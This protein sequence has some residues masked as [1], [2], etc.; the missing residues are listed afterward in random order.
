MKGYYVVCGIS[1]FQ[2]LPPEAQ[3]PAVGTDLP[4]IEDLFRDWMKMEAALKGLP[5]EKPSLNLVLKQI[6]SW[7]GNL[8][9]E[10]S[11]VLYI[12]THGA[13]TATGFYLLETDVATL[14]DDSFNTMSCITPRQ[15]AETISK[16]SLKQVL[17]ILDCCH[18]AKG[19]TE[20]TAVHDSAD[21]KLGTDQDRKVDFLA[22]SRTAAV[23]D[24]QFAPAFSKI[25]RALGISSNDPFLSLPEIVQSLKSDPALSGDKVWHRS[26]LS[27]TSPCQRL[28]NGSA[29]G[30]V[31]SESGKQRIVER[32]AEGMKHSGESTAGW[33]CFAWHESGMRR[34]S[35]NRATW[36]AQL[37]D[38]LG[39]KSGAIALLEGF[40]LMT[41]SA[42]PAEQIMICVQEE[43]ATSIEPDLLAKEELLKDN[44][45]AGR[46]S[47]EKY[48]AWT[49]SPT[50]IHIER[51][52]GKPERRSVVI[53]GIELPEQCSTDDGH[54]LKVICKPS[55]SIHFIVPVKS[56]SDDFEGVPVFGQPVG[57]R[58]AVTVHPW[59]RWM[60]QDQWLY[61]R[62]DMFQKWKD[63]DS[64]GSTI[65]ASGD[66]LDELLQGGNP[67][68]L[69]P[70]GLSF[71]QAATFGA[72]PWQLW[73]RTL[74]AQR[75]ASEATATLIF[76]S[77]DFWPTRKSKLE[78][79]A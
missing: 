1:A 7:A 13:C 27:F 31:L 10:A 75:K 39:R 15:I 38:R 4:L 42:D 50:E 46:A 21:L 64:N 40:L 18:A 76:D 34:L 63:M 24:G 51:P 79:Q 16:P 19:I 35:E 52:H 48:R 57:Y 54:P 20:F 69:F 2:N 12:S 62:E 23:P 45:I 8:K 6:Q 49:Q 78:L 25:A 55:N 22:S 11:L 14:A 77:P 37:F 41:N 44:R 36:Q 71:P 65:L 61:A 29:F 73:P 32:L 9:E 47:F 5:A 70:K 3:L 59:E 28:P 66:G 30:T 56:L 53:N 33:L 58:H 60:A 17:V 67:V 74:M 43:I 72:V 68:L 26:V